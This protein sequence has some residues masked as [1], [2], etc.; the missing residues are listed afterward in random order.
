MKIEVINA[1]IQAHCHYEGLCLHVEFSFIELHHFILAGPSSDLASGMRKNCFIEKKDTNVVFEALSKRVL[2]HPNHLGE[3]H[4]I[5]INFS[6]PVF[7]ML[8]FDFMGDIYSANCR[9]TNMDLWKLSM[10]HF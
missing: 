10:K 9:W 1:I 6:F 4:D 7:D 2:H 8:E 5:K 3:V